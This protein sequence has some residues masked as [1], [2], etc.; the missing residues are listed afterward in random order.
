MA[1]GLSDTLRQMAEG[2]HG[3]LPRRPAAEPAAA[4]DA[5][6][7]HEEREASLRAAPSVRPPR[8]ASLRSTE[9]RPLQ[10]V[11]AAVLLIMGLAMAA[12]GGWAT[13]ILAGHEVWR[14]DQPGARSV[15]LGLLVAYPMALCLLGA[16]AVLIKRA[17]KF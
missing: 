13:M 1:D 16:A 12:M 14:S 3:S 9:G 10:A 11:A 7:T 6:A 2:E 17:W 5:A 8:A 4:A 15:A